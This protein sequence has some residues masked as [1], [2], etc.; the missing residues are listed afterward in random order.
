MKRNINILVLAALLYGAQ[1]SAESAFPTPSPDDLPPLSGISYADQRAAELA[2]APSNDPFPAASPDDV[3]P[4]SGE[5]YADRHAADIARQPFSA[6]LAGNADLD[7]LPSEY[8]YA[9]MHRHEFAQ[10]PAVSPVAI[11]DGSAAV[12]AN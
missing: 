4:L 10:S 7:P 1:A 2:S 11:G 6:V 9:D 5:T 3:P 8:T 12:A